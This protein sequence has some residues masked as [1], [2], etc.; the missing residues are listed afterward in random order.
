MKIL[1]LNPN[2][3]SKY[4]QGHYLFK[5]E[6]GKHHEVTYYGKGY[7]NYDSS[8]TVPRIL[9]NLNINFDLIL[10]Y[11]AKYSRFFEG[12]GKIKNIPK[13]HI[14]IDY[15]LNFKK[16]RGFADMNKINKLITANKP[17][18]IFAT[19][20]SNVERLKKSLGTEKVFFL[21]FSVDTAIYKDLNMNRT[22]DAMA[23]FN[24]RQY[25]Y[26]NREKVQRVLKSMDINS[27]TSRVIKD[28]YVKKLNQSKMFVISNNIN[29]RL[30]MKYTEAM[31][32]GTF[33]LAD[34]PEDMS[35]QGFINGKHLVLYEN[36]K[37]MKDKIRYY[38]K[39]DAQRKEIAL[40]GMKFVRKNHSCEKRVKQFT[41]IVKRELGI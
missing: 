23:V 36:L 32:C 35:L 39:H 19:A 28:K 24:T 15:A 16:Y 31:A 38:L 25:V 37:D 33:V 4:N 12:L 11:E 5:N 41:D 1:L 18:I 6:F 40:E 7:P 9:E 17:D 21:P 27:F 29:N 30:S 20:G 26:P 34:E 3:S 13:A 2:H 22:I 10:T 8:L 14:Q